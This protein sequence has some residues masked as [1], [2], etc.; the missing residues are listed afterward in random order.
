MFL[1]MSLWEPPL[2]FPHSGIALCSVIKQPSAL[3]LLAEKGIAQGL[4]GWGGEESCPKSRSE[5]WWPRADVTSTL[6]C[7]WV[8]WLRAGRWT[9]GC[10]KSGRGCLV[11]E[12]S[13]KSCSLSQLLSH[14]GSLL[15]S[16][17]VTI[18][19]WF[20]TALTRSSPNHCH[21]VQKAN[22]LC[23]EP[24]FLLFLW[25]GDCWSLRKLWF[26]ELIPQVC[27]S[28]QQNIQGSPL[29]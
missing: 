27:H 11:V 17:S 1:S 21:K 29:Y 5:E 18:S 9:Q 10:P 23:V 16:V 8:K 13:L 26:S 2:H 22:L 15:F 7:G 14:Y 28:Q 25:M 3:C 12:S 19:F 24:K 6:L 4:Q 20:L